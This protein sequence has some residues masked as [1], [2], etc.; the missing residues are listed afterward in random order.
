MRHGPPPLDHRHHK[1]DIA[2][3]RAKRTAFED[4][5]LSEQGQLDFDTAVAYGDWDG[6]QHFP[7]TVIADLAIPTAALQWWREHQDQPQ[8]ARD[9]VGGVLVKLTA[10][11]R[12]SFFQWLDAEAPAEAGGDLVRRQLNFPEY[13][14]DG[15][16]WYYWQRE[17]ADLVIN[18]L[19][20]HTIHLP[21]PQ[22]ARRLGADGGNHNQVVADPRMIAFVL[23][24]LRRLVK[25]L[26]VRY[27]SA[28]DSARLTMAAVRVTDAKVFCYVIMRVALIYAVLFKHMRPTSRLTVAQIF[29]EVMSGR[30]L[31]AL[32][33]LD[34]EKVCCRWVD[35]RTLQWSAYIMAAVKHMQVC[36]LHDEPP[37]QKWDAVWHVTAGRED[38][39][40]E[41]EHHPLCFWMWSGEV[42]CN[43]VVH[44]DSLCAADQ[45][46]AVWREDDEVW[47]VFAGVRIP[48]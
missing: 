10:D 29:R 18:H 45:I 39:S 37:T 32:G 15:H 38:A 22:I 11:V 17:A 1:T 7:R 8:W 19:Q 48:G 42:H 23:K 21:G 20:L 25:D 41:N 5:C 40:Q 24:R 28:P 16:E 2:S 44:R 31:L 47:V 9:K 27:G 35:Q 13:L 26:I 12:A 6:H 3:P 36:Y 33:N 4:D 30:R 14:M 46:A 34:W 43:S